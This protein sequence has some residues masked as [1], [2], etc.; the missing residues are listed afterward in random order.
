MIALSAE[1]DTGGVAAETVDWEVVGVICC[2]IQHCLH[3]A[4][5]GFASNGKLRRMVMTG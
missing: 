2:D 1:F 3:A 4:D 5:L